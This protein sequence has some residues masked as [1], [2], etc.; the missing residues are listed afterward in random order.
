MT[1]EEFNAKYPVG[2]SCRYFP[3]KGDGYSMQTRTRSEAWELGSGHVGVAIENRS[4]G[5]SV[6]HL[7]MES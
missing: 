1:A 7:I 5:V 6:G 2:S 4:G 3:L